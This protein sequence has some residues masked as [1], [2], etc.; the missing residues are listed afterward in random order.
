MFALLGLLGARRHPVIG[1]YLAPGATTVRWVLISLD[2]DALD[3]AVG[4]WLRAHAACDEHGWA[5][6]V[7]GKDRS[8]ARDA[9]PVPETI[10]Q[11]PDRAVNRSLSG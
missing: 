2:A 9:R 10:V 4:G 5:I 6:A 11:C 1:R 7:D 3:S 8:H